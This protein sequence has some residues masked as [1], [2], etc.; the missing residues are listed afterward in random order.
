MTTPGT[1]LFLCGDVMTG[2]GVD[3]ALPHPSA[4]GLHEPCVESPVDYLDLAE[5]AHGPISKPVGFSYIWGDAMDELERVKPAAR[6]INLETSVTTSEQYEPKGI[7]YRMHPENTPCLTAAKIDCCVL[8]NNHVLDWTRD[9]LVETLATLRGAGIHTAG[10]GRNLAEAQEPAIIGMHGNARVLVFGMGLT[11]SGIPPDWAATGTT[12]GVALLPDSSDL[13]IARI[14]EQVRAIKRAGDVA[15][16][17][18]HWGPNWGYRISREHRRLAHR[19]IEET[20]IDLIHGHS[21]HH[22]K[23]IEVHRGKLIL[24]GCGDFLNDYEG[25]AGYE[26]YRS[27]LALMYFV[28]VEPDTG[29][30]LRLEMTPL[31]IRRFRLNHA[32]RPDAVW[33]QETLTREGKQTGTELRLTAENR[34]VLQWPSRELRPANLAE[35]VLDDKHA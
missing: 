26:E 24:Y 20:G 4:P 19:L 18:V 3:Q 33:L 21:S 31:E 7:N 16:M 6:I 34:L 15:V 11:D 35:H 9:G 32:R 25:I 2:R 22:P 17:S 10:A 30:L 12:P 29:N 13:Q 23:P 27:H 5:R 1:T 8:A 28:T 14:A